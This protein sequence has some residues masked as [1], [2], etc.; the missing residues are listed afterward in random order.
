LNVNFAKMPT[1]TL[2]GLTMPEMVSLGIDFPKLGNL[3]LGSFIN[4]SGMF[5]FKAFDFINY[6]K[7]FDFT[8]KMKSLILSD[9]S[10]TN[11]TYFTAA[12]V[13][14]D[15]FAGFNEGTS[16]EIGFKVQ[17]LDI[18]AVLAISST[19]DKYFSL[20]GSSDY[21]GFVGM[22]VFELKADHLNFAVN[23]ADSKGR[24]IDYK[25]KNLAIPQG[26]DFSGAVSVPLGGPDFIMNMDGKNG[27]TIQL[28]I[29]NALIALDGFLYVSGNFAFKKSSISGVHIGTDNPLAIILPDDITSFDYFSVAASEVDIF[30]GVKGPYFGAGDPRNSDSPVGIFAN[31]ID[32]AL[33]MFTEKDAKPGVAKRKFN[34]LKAHVA[35][36]GIVGF[37]DVLTASFKNIDI[38]YNSSTKDSLQLYENWIDFDK[39]FA[40]GTGKPAGLAIATGGAP[41]Y[42]DMDSPIMAA[43]IGLAEI[44]VSQFL[45]LRGSFA[46]SKGA[47]MTVDMDLGGFKK[48]I[49]TAGGAITGNELDVTSLPIQV[50]A[51][52][53]GGSNLIGFVGVGGPYRYGEDADNDG[54]PDL[55]NEAAVGLMIDDVDFGLAI[56]TPTAL[57]FLPESLKQY[58]PKFLT[59]KA[60]VG[61]AMLVGI[62]K[63][64]MTVEAQ[65][66][67]VNINTFYWPL[68][69]PVTE[70]A[71]NAAIQLFGPPTINYQTSFGGA[72]PEDKNKNGILDTYDEDKNFN[73]VLDV[74]EDTNNNGVLD[75]TEDLDRNGRL[76]KNGY[77][78]WTGGNTSVIM[79][80]AGG[81]IQAKVAYAEI[82][83]AGFVQLS[84]SM[85][86]TLRNGEEVTLSNGEKTSI[87][88]LSIGISD[89][90]G[91]IGVPSDVAG[92]S[93]KQGYFYDSNHDGRITSSEDKNLNGVLDAGEDTNYNGIFDLG[94]Q[95]NSGAIGLAIENL[96]IGVLVGAEIGIGADGLTVGVYLAAQA[97]IDK[98]GLVGVDSVVLEAKGLM[99]DLNVGARFKLST[100]YTK[101]EKTG[102]VSFQRDNAGI[103]IL[104]TTIDFSKSTW[105]DTKLA[106]NQDDDKTN[107]IIHAGYAIETGDSAKPIVLMYKDIYLRVAGQA[108][109]AV[110]V[111]GDKIIDITGAF[112]I[113]ASTTGL[114]IFVDVEAKIGKE[115]VL[116]LDAHALGLLVVGEVEDKVTHEVTSG[117]AIKLDLTTSFN[118]PGTDPAKPILS[119][120]IKL[121]F[122]MNSFGKDVVYD[123]PEDFWST[124]I[125]GKKDGVLDYKTVTISATPPTKSTPTDFYI[126]LTAEG[127]FRLL[128]VLSFQGH[129]GVLFSVS[130]GNTVLAE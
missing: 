12:I 65:E 53:I 79:D 111:N 22:P 123:V 50:E 69:D 129:I 95:R 23:T 2:P 49:N 94:D 122:A 112:E 93:A 59:V 97:S 87:T 104:P 120:D 45:H 24:V 28:E 21:F 115:G 76:A 33:A 118:I 47:R 85:A 27:E 109:L 116:V 75:L 61:T 127:E 7:Q 117:V 48:I 74:G 35:E 34:T 36:V 63:D 96:N 18:G 26:L 119:S 125:G 88:S 91:F 17:N 5:H 43:G 11:V 68:P 62:D 82:N 16:D 66:I 37:G 13:D 99:L 20:Q 25:A 41:I 100:G 108:E 54:L 83:L 90:N 29:N 9:G 58:I 80:F 64:L 121:K 42:L 84:A 89:A 57:G 52:T 4:L 105:M 10:T 32:I 101:D 77:A 71:V 19:G 67:S 51:L 60:N 107:D 113:K 106:V 72:S 40:A 30:A 103:S 102:A 81:I 46:F 128:D 15:L 130:D 31:D 3:G 39:S 38:K 1:F 56:M 55:I 70:L 86:F 44:Q 92:Y 6:D 14:L 78:L 110:L 8:I 98:I 73:G 114:S 126:S 124:A